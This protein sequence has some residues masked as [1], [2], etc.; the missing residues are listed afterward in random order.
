[1]FEDGVSTPRRFLAGVSAIVMSISRMRSFHNDQIWRRKFQ[2]VAN[3]R[4][5]RVPRDE[6]DPIEVRQPLT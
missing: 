3:W 5:T 6:F 1:V 2:A 4:Q